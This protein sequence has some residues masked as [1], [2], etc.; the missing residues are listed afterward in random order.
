M[1]PKEFLE[2]IGDFT[3]L[4]GM[5]FFIETAVGSFVW[6]DPDYNGDNTIRYTSKSYKDY[7]K[8]CHIGYGRDKGKHIIGRYI[9]KDPIFTK[10]TIG[11]LAT[12]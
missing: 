2:T 7:L 12:L 1:S 9:G 10:A 5:E 4:F 3:W 8:E 11:K 6:R